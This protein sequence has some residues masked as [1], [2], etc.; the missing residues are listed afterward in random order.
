MAE[1][2]VWLT[3]VLEKLSNVRDLTFESELPVYPLTLHDLI[4]NK[5]PLRFRFSYEI[6]RPR[7]H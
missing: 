1:V 4:A 2:A 7:L 6:L 5:S 3:A